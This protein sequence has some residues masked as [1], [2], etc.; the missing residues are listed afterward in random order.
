LRVLLYLLLVSLP[1]SL[2]GCLGEGRAGETE[3]GTAEPELSHEAARDDLPGEEIRWILPESLASGEHQHRITQDTHLFVDKS[4]SLMPRRDGIVRQ[5]LVERGDFVKEG[6][7]LLRLENRELSLFVERAEIALDRQRKEF[8]RAERLHEQKMISMSEFEEEEL[9]W[10]GAR[11]E[12]EITK[13]RLEKT[14]LRAPFDG[15]ITERD[16]RVGQKVFEDDNIPLFRITQMSDL[17]ARLFLEERVARSLQEGQ[18]VEISPRFRPDQ[19]HR[20]IVEY[21]CPEV[22]SSSGTVLSIISIP[23]GATPDPLRPGTGVTVSLWTPTDGTTFTVPRIAFG[24]DMTPVPGS[25]AYLQVWQDGRISLRR[26]RI[27]EILGDR[28]EITEGLRRV[29]KVVLQSDGVSNISSL[30]RSPDGAP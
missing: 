5:I 27:G 1:L 23:D 18:E 21:I 7:P 26:V 17:Q 8:E 20:G 11:V 4:V 28:V 24:D 29:D 3:P 16:V 30:E 9:D 10:Q 22:D 19:V 12:L 25:S 15:Q 2:S 13:E 14:W 6:D